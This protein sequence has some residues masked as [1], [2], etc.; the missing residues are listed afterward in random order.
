MYKRVSRSVYRFIKTPK[1]EPRTIDGMIGCVDEWVESHTRFKGK[2]TSSRV[3]SIETWIS[4]FQ[5]QGTKDAGD[6]R[7]R[8]KFEERQISRMQAAPAIAEMLLL[9]VHLVV[10]S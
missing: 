4:D 2:T 7:M 3:S 8:I 5:D 10:L 9:S 6:E 1:P